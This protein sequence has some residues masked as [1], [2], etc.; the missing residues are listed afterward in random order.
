LEFSGFIL[1]L[2]S[3]NSWDLCGK[4]LL[5]PVGND[6]RLFHNIAISGFVTTNGYWELE[7]G[8]PAPM[9][10]GGGGIIVGTCGAVF[11]RSV[12]LVF[13]FSRNNSSVHESKGEG[14]SLDI[15]Y[16]RRTV[17]TQFGLLV[18]PLRRDIRGMPLDMPATE[19]GMGCTYSHLLS[20]KKYGTDAGAVDFR[21]LTVQCS[22]TVGFS[23]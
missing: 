2:V 3:F 11:D 8:P 7:F 20:E 17:D 5:F 21:N 12:E 22:M 23:R 9:I 16:K 1:P 18:H 13:S 19:I 14:V 6:K 15:D 4:V 10:N